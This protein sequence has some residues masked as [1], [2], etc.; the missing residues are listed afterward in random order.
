MNIFVS[1]P[2]PV[3]SAKYLDNRRII[4]M[5]LESMQ[6]LSTAINYYGGT[7]PYKTT[8]KDHP[9]TKWVIES[10]SNAEWLVKHFKALCEEYTK[11]YN[12]THKCESYIESIVS[13]LNL[14]PDNGLISFVN[15]TNFKD[16]ANVHEAYRVALND[17]WEKDFNKGLNVKWE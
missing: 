3:E 5:T 4:K 17:K 2:C 11:R 13:Q 12:K 10:R 15:C 16:I 7:G 8:H 14:I 1:S 9:C 6:L